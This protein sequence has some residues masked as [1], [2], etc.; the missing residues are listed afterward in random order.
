M[1]GRLFNT[2]LVF[3]ELMPDWNHLALKWNFGRRDGI[4]RDT[5]YFPI[6]VRSVYC[7]R[8][9]FL[10][11][12]SVYKHKYRIHNGDCLNGY[13]GPKFKFTGSIPTRP[14]DVLVMCTNRFKKLKELKEVGKIG[15]SLHEQGMPQQHYY[16]N[17]RTLNILKRQKMIMGR[18]ECRAWGYRVV[19][20]N[21]PPTSDV[22]CPRLSSR[23]SW[24]GP[25]M[26]EFL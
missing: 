23:I 3:R 10:S 25:F 16:D 21:K 13:Y 19:F 14:I 9:Y 7:W 26:L 5:S 2:K 22:I 8:T 15:G 12:W 1:E 11:I 6:D 17:G 20:W 18:Y 4:D 24:T